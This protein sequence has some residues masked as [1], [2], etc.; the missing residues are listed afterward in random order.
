M[1]VE[2]R[3]LVFALRRSV[4]R[5][6]QRSQSESQRCIRSRLSLNIHNQF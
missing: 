3:E 2:G 4:S 1:L 5:I 6:R